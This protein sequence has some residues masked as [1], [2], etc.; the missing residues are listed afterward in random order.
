[1]KLK[2]LTDSEQTPS[3]QRVNASTT[4]TTVFTWRNHSSSSDL[5]IQRTRSEYDCVL[6]CCLKTLPRWL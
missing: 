4:M 2:Q 5:S 1:M 6:A 3:R